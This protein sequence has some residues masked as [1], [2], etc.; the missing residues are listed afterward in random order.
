M[1]ISPVFTRYQ[2]PQ[3]P[4]TI[5]RVLV[6]MAM[7]QG[8]E[9]GDYIFS[10]SLFTEY[11]RYYSLPYLLDDYGSPPKVLIQVEHDMGLHDFYL[12]L[13]YADQGWSAMFRMPLEGN[14]ANFV[15]CPDQSLITLWLWAPEDIESAT[16]YGYFLPEI[17][18]FTTLEEATSLTLDEFYQQFKDPENTQC[19]ET[20]KDIWTP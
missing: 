5:R 18:I 13:D 6:D 9:Y 2:E 10:N 12:Y 1:V 11:T 14:D 19:L 3:N 4:E 17:N 15:G 7:H 16:R 20:P 8:N